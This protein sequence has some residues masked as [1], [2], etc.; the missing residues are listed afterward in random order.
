MTK[1]TQVVK[2]I[3]LSEELMNYLIDKKIKTEPNSSFVIFI[4]GN[5]ELNKLN[6]KLVDEL[7]EE[8]KKVIKATKTKDKTN[9]WILTTIN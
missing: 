5:K 1:H 2:N 8:G 6:L 4:E 3:E 7:L 9:P